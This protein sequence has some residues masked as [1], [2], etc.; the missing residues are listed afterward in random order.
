MHTQTLTLTATFFTFWSKHKRYRS[1]HLLRR[2]FQQLVIQLSFAGANTHAPVYVLWLHVASLVLT[3]VA[4][5]NHTTA[6]ISHTRPLPV[7]HTR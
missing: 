7:Y 6:P 5:C 3:G 4:T 2:C 1:G